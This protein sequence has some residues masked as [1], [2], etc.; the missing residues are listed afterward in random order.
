MSSAGQ[1]LTEIDSDCSV[2]EWDRIYAQD[3][4]ALPSQSVSWANAIC[5]TGG[6]EIQR[7]RYFFSDGIEAALSLFSK[8]RSGNPFRIQR[9]PPPAWGFG[10]PISTRPLGPGH[11]SAIL[12]DCAR[13]PGAAIQIRPNP[14]IARMW[15]EAVEGSRWV[16]LPRHAHVVDL[17]GGFEAIWTKRFHA[18]TRANARK[19]EKQGITVDSGSSAELAAEF[20]GLFRLSIIR[21]AGKQKEYQWLA[22]LRGQLRDPKDKFLEMA[23][24]CGDLLQVKIARKDGEAIAGIVVL[25]GHN[26][27]YTRGAMNDQTIGN[28]GANALLHSLAIEEACARNCRS[29]HMG[30]SGA[31]ASLATF[32]EKFGAIGYPYAEYRHERLPILSMDQKL[33]TLVKRAIGF[34]D[35]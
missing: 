27:H 24:L 18:K 1:G 15:A 29:Y 16:A 3:Q 8:S 26:A 4:Q 34:R 23:R 19:A 10:G 21:W 28:S 25:Y 30:E 9:S 6:Y 20:D 35:V 12:D 7:R 33:R 22:A 32:K 11:L 13:L 5:K 31:S 17:D 2:S 14:L